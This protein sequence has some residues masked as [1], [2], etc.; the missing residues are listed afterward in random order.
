M[1]QKTASNT[2]T[3]SE[4]G[5]VAPSH[6]DAEQALLG[7]IMLEA[8]YIV[9]VAPILT[10]RDFYV[11]RHGM[12]YA[13]MLAIYERSEPIDFLTVVSELEKNNKLNAVGGAAYLTALLNA[14]PTAIN[15]EHYALM[16]RNASNNRRLLSV[17]GEIAGLAF[18]NQDYSATWNAASAAL[19]KCAPNAKNSFS[20]VD[21]VISDCILDA[22]LMI[23]EPRFIIGLASGFK[24]FDRKL[25]GLQ[26]GLH[27][28][29]G[30]TSMGK[31]AMMLGAARN[32]S[33][34]G[35]RV[36]VVTLEMNNKKL[37]NR[38]LAYE[39]K[40]PT[41]AIESGY[42]QTDSM[43]HDGSKEYRRF[44]SDEIKRLEDAGQSI[45]DWHLKLL[46]AAGATSLSVCAQVRELY[47][48]EGV[49]V[50]YVDYVQLLTDHEETDAKA[51]DLATR[52]LLQLSN[53]LNIPVVVLSQLKR[54][55]EMRDSKLP[56]L[57][58][59]RGSGGIE[60]NADVV[61]T[62]NNEDYWHKAEPNYIRKNVQDVL[63][64]KDRLGGAAG[65]ACQL[66]FVEKL[67]MLADLEKPK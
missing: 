25:R 52:N 23:D 61:V 39:S 63:I 12:I 48:R 37:A 28:W 18:D 40:I 32:Q 33:R 49:D 14:V 47:Q 62:F 45:S 16:V 59:A 11:D 2:T 19:L 9:R 57:S 55:L 56:S 66:A 8:G 42:I 7:G 30:A 44:T 13:A 38:L 5:V 41:A 58:D 54:G 31:T 4:L 60:Q 34:E 20:S 43:I 46:Y 51:L 17:T 67:G 24:D 15:T 64:L 10:V 36:A 1:E 6:R 65:K 35:K 50:V 29:M 53:D 27:V 22:R 3:M 26:A 21:A